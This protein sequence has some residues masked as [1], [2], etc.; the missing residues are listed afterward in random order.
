MLICW[1]GENRSV[2]ACVAASNGQRSARWLEVGRDGCELS[3]GVSA[4]RVVNPATFL[5]IGHE[6]SVL[7][8]FQMER[9]TRLRDVE[10]ILEVAH[11]ALAVVQHLDDRE[12]CLVGQGVKELGRS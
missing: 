7:E 12:A 10:S 11:A 8:H 3:E 6:A 9:Q 4:E 5:S 2:A 1:T